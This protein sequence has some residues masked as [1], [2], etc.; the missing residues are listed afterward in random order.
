MSDYDVFL[1]PQFYSFPTSRS[2]SDTLP[3]TLR[4]VESHIN[5]S[6]KWKGH[7]YATWAH[8]VSHL[9]SADVRIKYRRENN[10]PNINAFYVLES[11]AVVLNEPD[12][13]LAQVAAKIP[14]KDRGRLYQM[15]LVQQQRHWNKQ[16]L[17][18]CDEW[19]CYFIDA[20]VSIEQG[21]QPH[22]G[23]L[24][25]VPY[26]KMVAQLAIQDA[27]ITQFVAWM[28]MQCDSLLNKVESKYMRA[29]RSRYAGLE[30]LPPRPCLEQ[31]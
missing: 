18:V 28:E 21:E 13:T 10:F 20:K 27:A 14:A 15:Y 19:V 16:P 23:F 26:A 29:G 2:A 22:Q 12:L 25:F 8:E 3:P 9:I 11:R 1:Q 6:H 31:R 5:R 30:E 4:D 17:Y 24:E 7:D